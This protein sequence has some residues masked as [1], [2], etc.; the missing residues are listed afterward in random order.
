MP[1]VVANFTQG[2]GIGAR[3]AETQQER[4]RA[5]VL[6]P[7]QVQQMQMQMRSQMLEY[8]IHQ[9]AIADDIQTKAGMAELAGIASGIT[10]WADDAQTGKLFEAIKRYP[11]L[12]SQPIMRDFTQRIDN[13]R[14]ADRYLK[15]A[16]LRQTWEQ[17]RLDETERYHRDLIA[18][19]TAAGA[20]GTKEYGEPVEKKFPGVGTLIYRPGSP[21]G[22]F[23]PEKQATPISPAQKLAIAKELGTMRA[24]LSA[25]KDPKQ[26]E[27]QIGAINALEAALKNA[28]SESSAAPA[29]PQEDPNDP[30]GIF[31]DPPDIEE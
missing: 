26:K 14:T 25:I 29:Q 22:H 19:K 8:D 3:F 2:L 30:L 10:N 17:A 13:A 24:T 5:A 21:G 28:P 16:Q 11:S 15:V 6:L 23:A 12:A 7:L 31:K 27:A 4:Q 1:D 20:A 9:R 18:A